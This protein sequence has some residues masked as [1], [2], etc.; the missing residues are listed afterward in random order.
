MDK[1]LRTIMTM[2]GVLVFLYGWVSQ[3]WALAHH[4]AA[5]S[6]GP[7]FDWR[8]RI[9]R[10]NWFASDYGYRMYR[11]AGWNTLIGGLMLLAARML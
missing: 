4:R 11:W 9:A 3:M 10:R 2:T 5:N 1:E 7:W 8:P 6:T